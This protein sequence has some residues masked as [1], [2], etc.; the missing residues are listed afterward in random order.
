MRSWEPGTTVETLKKRARY[1]D[2]IRAFFRERGVLE[3]ET[4]ALSM[5]P[6]VDIHIES[7]S[8]VAHSRQN[9]RY[10]ITSPE[11][12]MKRLL[13]AGSG[14]IFQICKAFRDDETGQWHNP[15]FTIIEW[16][17]VGWDQWQ[18]MDE[19]DQLLGSLLGCG[20]ADRKRY[21]E[22]F[23]SCLGIDPFA[24]THDA[25]I[26][27]C[28]RAGCPPPRHLLDSSSSKD[29]WLDYLMG[30]HIES[31]LGEKAPVFIYN[32]PASQACLAKI[33]PD[34][35]DTAMRFEIFYQG[36]ELG[37]GFQELTCAEQQKQRFDTVNRIRKK[38]GQEELEQDFRLLDALNAG[39]P[40]CSGVAMGFDR[41][42]MLVTG[43]RHMED[44]VSFAWDRC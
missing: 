33:N 32:Y 14:S 7:I 34:N 23:G 40:E 3:V 10:L 15:E 11:Y 31:R 42:L 30:S 8:T 44:V 18:L 24:I 5:Y 35:P 37:N 17:R 1:L 27:A 16:Y 21:G 26:A 20:P 13:A 12:H 41:L 22:V 6:S 2:K 43:K 28:T 19:I 29:D 36:R 9:S 39:L 4:P 25:F 38:Q